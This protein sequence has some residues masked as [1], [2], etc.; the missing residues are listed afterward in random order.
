MPRL[1]IVVPKVVSFTDIPT[2]S[3]SVN[4]L[5]TS[6]FFHTLLAAATL[7]MCKGCVFIVSSENHLL[8]ASVM[9]RVHSW[10]KTRPGSNSSNHKPAM[11][12]LLRSQ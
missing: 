6:G 12:I 8:S 9:V 4:R 2:I 11:A 5:L 3:P 10:S 7:S 1:A